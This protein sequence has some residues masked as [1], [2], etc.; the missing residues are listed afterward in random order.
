[1][2]VFA[3]HAIYFLK[4]HVHSLQ[5]D[6]EIGVKQIAEKILH[7]HFVWEK[8]LIHLINHNVALTCYDDFENHSCHI[9]FKQISQ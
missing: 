6:L 4:N 1:M 5:K 2:L 8:V 3:L 9:L 7:F